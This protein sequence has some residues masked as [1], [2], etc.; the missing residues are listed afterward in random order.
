MLE[1]YFFPQTEDLDRET[2]NLVICMQD[3][4]PPHFCQF[5]HKALNDKF[6][7]A[8]T[9]RG[10]PIFWPSR[11]PDLTPMDFFL[12]GYVKNI[13]YGEKI[14]DI[15]HLQDRITAAITTVTSDMIMRT[16]HEIR[17]HLDICQATNG[18]HIETY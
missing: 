17:Y 18:A 15:Q 12:W 3:R 16:W 13:V 14:C 8:W 6:P 9:G 7:N 10:G 11:S 2:G 1:N 5:V 4:A